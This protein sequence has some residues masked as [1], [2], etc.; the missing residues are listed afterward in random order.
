V[1]PKTWR[2][3]LYVLGNG[4]QFVG[5]VLESPLLKRQ[6]EAK[7]REHR[8]ILQ[9]QADKIRALNAEVTDLREAVETLKDILH[10][11]KESE[12]RAA[13]KKGLE[14]KP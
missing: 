5:S 9:A 10:L 11:L 13:E 4:L 6:H 3:L 8:S 2:A 14:E 1:K 7:E 12:E